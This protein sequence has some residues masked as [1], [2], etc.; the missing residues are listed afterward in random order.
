MNA[1]LGVI[2]LL[3]PNCLVHQQNLQNL[4]GLS[5][6]EQATFEVANSASAD[7]TLEQ[8]LAPTPA[9]V[10]YLGFLMLIS[11]RVDMPLH[12]SASYNKTGLVEV[13]KT[14]G[15]A[16]HLVSEKGWYAFAE[17]HKGMAEMARR[18]A[19]VGRLSKK[20]E[21]AANSGSAFLVRT[22]VPVYAEQLK[23]NV[24]PFAALTKSVASRFMRMSTLL[25]EVT[26]AVV[27][28]QG[29]R[30]EELK[31]IDQKHKEISARYEA[32]QTKSSDLK[33][34]I[35]NFEKEN[36]KYNEKYRETLKMLPTRPGL[37]APEIKFDLTSFLFT[38]AIFDN[39][40]GTGVQAVESLIGFFT[41]ALHEKLMWVK[42]GY[43]EFVDKFLGRFN[44]AV[45]RKLLAEEILKFN[46]YLLTVND[47]VTNLPKS[48]T[49]LNSTWTR[50][51]CDAGKTLIS[52]SKKEIDRKDIPQNDANGGQFSKLLAQ[53][54]KLTEDDICNANWDSRDEISKG[55]EELR[56]ELEGIAKDARIEI[57]LDEEHLNNGDYKHW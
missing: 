19:K 9:M 20:I 22:L 6:Q 26:K 15:S 53:G 1:K 27:A 33:N 4:S 17:A 3:L 54:L 43:G 47:Q 42:E 23:R 51:T 44:F 50:Q 21:D 45:S 55:I 30:E 18:A 38:K 10:A 11:S 46:M 56:Q 24:A 52:L 35:I 40:G 14:T 12:V 36:A 13:P 48:Q 32:L 16:L 28:S 25:L 2:C 31:L 5:V 8:C 57:G 39:Y 49:V 29:S 7:S 34:K 37:K 41:P